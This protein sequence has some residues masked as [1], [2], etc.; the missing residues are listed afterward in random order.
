MDGEYTVER[1]LF[2]VSLVIIGIALTV[3][4]WM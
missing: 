4:W 2:I 3:R 1:L